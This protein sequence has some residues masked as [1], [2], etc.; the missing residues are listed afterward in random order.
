[1]ISLHIIKTIFTNIQFN[2]IPSATLY[3]PSDLF[4]A[5]VCTK[6]LP[7]SFSSLLHATSHVH[8]ILIN[9]A[10]YSWRT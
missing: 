4:H 5:V 9:V 8:P 10:D 6:A 1:M 7:L 2:N 3:F